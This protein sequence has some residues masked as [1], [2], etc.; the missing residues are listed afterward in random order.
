[1]KYQQTFDIITL[2][3]KLKDLNYEEEIKEKKNRNVLQ[4]SNVPYNIISNISL[5][6]H[7]IIPPNLRKIYPEFKEKKN[8]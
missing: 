1:M 5:N 8:H 6:N 2:E 7:N 4:D 3:N